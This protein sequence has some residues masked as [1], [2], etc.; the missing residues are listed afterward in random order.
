[1]FNVAR[2]VA[3]HMVENSTK[4]CIINIGSTTAWKSEKILIGYG[5]S[6]GAVNALTLPM[7]RDLARFSIRVVNV[8]PGL[9]LT[10]LS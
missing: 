5:A 3:S 6:K 10:P 7:A 1:M 8:S 9:I 4:G 2:L